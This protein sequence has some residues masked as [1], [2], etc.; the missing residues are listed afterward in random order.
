MAIVIRRLVSANTYIQGEREREGVGRLSDP[1]EGPSYTGGSGV[2]NGVNGVGRDRWQS[3]GET[4]GIQYSGG[5]RR[6]FT[7]G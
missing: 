7:T 4:A 5:S 6:G 1:K 3:A 2:R